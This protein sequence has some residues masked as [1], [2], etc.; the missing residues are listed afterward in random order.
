[1]G[2]TLEI[3]RKNGSEKQDK[4]P[5]RENRVLSLRQNKGFLAILEFVTNS[6]STGVFQNREE[7]E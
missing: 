1:M 4:G 6:T 3:G 2:Q 7:K 5:Y